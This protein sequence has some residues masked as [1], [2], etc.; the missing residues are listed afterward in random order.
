MA[1]PSPLIFGQQTD[2]DEVPPAEARRALDATWSYFIQ[3]DSLKGGNVT[4]GYCESDPRILDN[5]SGPASCLWAL[6][7]LILAYSM[8]SDSAFKRFNRQLASRTSKLRDTNPGDPL[9][10]AGDHGNGTIGGKAA[11]AKNSYRLAR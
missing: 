2:P 5:Y 11:G 3:R 10:I 7:S 8:S 9:T 1:A 4:Q 6:R